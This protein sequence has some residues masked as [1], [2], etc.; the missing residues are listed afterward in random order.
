MATTRTTANFKLRTDIWDNIIPPPWNQEN[1]VTPQGAWRPAA[2]LPVLFEKTNQQAGTD[3]FV[4]SVGKPVAQ[5]TEPL[6]LVP[7][8][9]RGAFNKTTATVVLTYTATD[10]EWGVIDLT[11]GAPYAVNGTTS[12]TALQVAKALVE[13]GLVPEDTV[14]SNP[15]ASNADVTAIIEAFISKPR[16]VLYTAAYKWGGLA[17]EGNQAYTNYN[18]QHAI[19]F[20]TEW[21]MKVPWRVASDTDADAFDVSAITTTDAVSGAGDFPQPGEVWTITALEDLARY[22]LDGEELVAFALAHKPVAKNTTRTPISCD[23]SG[24]LV[25]EKTSLA[26]VKAEGDWY[27]DPE[28]G[29]LFVHADTWTTL[30]TD[31]SDPT[32]SYY[33]YDD[34][35]IGASSE[36]WI[37]FDGEGTPGGYV[38]IDEKSN[39][40]TKGVSADILD[41]TDLPVG[42]IDYIYREPRQG[43]DKIKSAWNLTNAPKTMKMPGTA[44]LGYSDTITLPDEPIADSIVILTV[45]FI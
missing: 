20:V 32:F 26:A 36:E 14:A 3:A 7:A 33:Y 15:P 4:M 35:G 8:G 31:D 45:R 23:V 39:F 5:T 38:S 37:Y 19:Q 43:S 30:V 24:V 22:D 1:I 27:L 25:K 21:Q 6:T 42:R 29:L 28:V 16:G 12:Y 9:L 44:S 10:Y 40:V 34:A 18:K 2:W 41:S 17:E 11:T 13:R